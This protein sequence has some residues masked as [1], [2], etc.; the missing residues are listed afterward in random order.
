MV[1][2]V[3]TVVHEHHP[4]PPQMRGCGRMDEETGKE[5]EEADGNWHSRSH[6]NEAHGDAN[7]QKMG[8]GL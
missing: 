3:K 4:E 6:F 8:D 5:D 7:E 2:P 1:N